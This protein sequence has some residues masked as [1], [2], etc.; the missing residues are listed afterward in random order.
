MLGFSSVTVDVQGGSPIDYR[1]FPNWDSYDT[2]HLT[3]E[4]TT[5][6]DYGTT[7]NLYVVPEI[8]SVS[9]DS[10]TH[11]YTAKAWAKAGT[12]RSGATRRGV[13]TTLDSGT[14]AYDAGVNWGLTHVSI[15]GY[16]MVYQSNTNAGY[17][18]Q[19]KLKGEYN[20]TVIYETWYTSSQVFN[21]TAAYNNG[22]SGSYGEI[23]IA[24][25]P[26]NK[27]T[28]NPGESVVVK[29]QGKASSD[30]GLSDVATVTVSAAAIS[31]SNWS[32]NYKS[33][34]Y[35]YTASVKVNGTTYTSGNLSATNAYDN[36]WSGCYGTVGLD[37]TT[38]TTLNY[39]QSVTVYAQAKQAS[40]SPSKTNVASRTLTAPADNYTGGHDVVPYIGSTGTTSYSNRTTSITANGTYYAKAVGRSAAGAGYDTQVGGNNRTFTVNVSGP[41]SWGSISSHSSS[42]TGINKNYSASAGYHYF[43]MRF[44]IGGTT[45]KIQLHTTT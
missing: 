44:T 8:E 26:A 45:Y 21:A 7:Y 41:V 11:K 18:V 43:V 30:S 34:P 38:A 6:Q 13:A 9:W 17:K 5:S 22:W 2:A 20:G 29:A 32:L 31:T 16:N 36:G 33:S 39:G 1:L 35:T 40:G 27:T 19:T 24:T 3:V 12:S 10:S 28:L 15:T 4:R 37:S 25:N 23:A 14:E 42:Q